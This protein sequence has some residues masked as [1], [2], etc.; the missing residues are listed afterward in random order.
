MFKKLLIAN[1]G[2]IACRV[3]RTARRMGIDTVAVYSDA[4]VRALHAAI[5]DERVYLGPAPATQSYLVIDKII[6]ACRKTGA[7]AVHPGYGFLSEQAAFAEALEDA[8]IVFIGPSARA[9]ATMGDKIEGKKLA[10]RAGVATVPG[11]AGAIETAARA[12]KAA[13]EIGYPVMIKAS[14]G[15]GGKGM[16]VAH[17]AAEVKEGYGL[18]RAEAASAFNDDRVFIEK[19]IADPRHIEIQVLGDKHGNIIHLGEREC[20]IQRR[21]QKIIEEAPSPL[22]DDVTRRRMGEQAVS[23]A[24]AVRYDSAGTVEFI[25]AND[26]SFHFLE[27][28]TRLQVEHPVTELVTGIDLVEEM[29]RIAAGEKLRFRQP[30]VR[31]RGW[32]VE[33]RI[34]AEDPVRNFLPST[35]RLITWRPPAEQQKARVSVR[36]DSGVIE[37]A[38]VPV[39]YDPLLAKLAVHAGDRN[40]AVQEMAAELDRFVISGVRNNLSL[41]SAVMASPRWKAGAL[42]TGFLDEEFPGGFRGAPLDDCLRGRLVAVAAVLDSIEHRRQ[43]QISGRMRSPPPGSSNERAVRLNQ[44]WHDVEVL[45]DADRFRLCHRGML[46]GLRSV[47]TSWQPGQSVV[48][49]VIDGTL[50]IVRVRRIGSGYHL[51]HRGAAASATVLGRRTAALVKLMPPKAETDGAKRLLC[52]MPGLVISIAVGEGQ[53]IKAGDTLAIV[54]AMKMQNVLRAERNAKVKRLTAR[55]GDSLAV[56]AVI[57][58]F[59]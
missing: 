40:G 19:Y 34:Y 42:S 25:A 4:D 17:S 51:E 49:A 7:E 48:E 43:R 57:M 5:A 15:G 23:L 39:H 52:P 58:E 10:A 11:H 22:L 27:M 50:I 16:R 6:E 18:A 37:G 30:D 44:E 20:S 45:E 26:R 41:L 3:I 8:G 53:D 56:D 59:E 29:I 31:A 14:A 55:P 28:N 38:E 13:S 24:R 47:E 32:S 54:E 36:L 2:E 21:N 9:I 46:E 1:R 33:C 35:G 12:V